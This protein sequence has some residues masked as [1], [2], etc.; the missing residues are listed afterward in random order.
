MTV[1]GSRR[2]E[3]IDRQIGYRATCTGAGVVVNV[4]TGTSSSA[5]DGQRKPECFQKNPGFLESPRPSAGRFGTARSHTR[6]AALIHLNIVMLR[7]QLRSG[8]GWE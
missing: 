1:E 3:S 4:G 7:R 8:E 5:V 6:Q 2:P